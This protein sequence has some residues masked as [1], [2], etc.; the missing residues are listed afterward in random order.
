MCRE[1]EVA[2]LSNAEQSGFVEV[3]S[4]TDQLLDE[5]IHEQMG[6]NL[7]RSEEK[8]DTD[9]HENALVTAREKMRKAPSFRI[10]K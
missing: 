7:Q 10:T 4:D 5:M 1:R 8:K 9:A 2:E 3:L 6:K